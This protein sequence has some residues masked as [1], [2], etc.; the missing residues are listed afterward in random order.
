MKL[1]D[2]V[3]GEVGTVIKP[4]E[5]KYKKKLP[6]SFGPL[7]DKI[8]EQLRVLN[9]AIFPVRY[10]DKFYSDVLAAGNFAQLAYYSTDILVGAAC[11]RREEMEGGGA[12]L[13]LMTIGV[14]APYR[15]CGVGTALAEALVE[16]ASKAADVNEVY[17]HVQSS[18]TKGQEFY[19]R[20]GFNVKETIANFYK[21]ID[22]PDCHVMVKTFDRSKT[23]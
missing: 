9:K 8:V 19:T 6:V 12:R 20:L 13:Y 1:E 3:S 22:P 15:S 5:Q 14:L 18:N 21:D 4:T 16:T 17:V 2:F 11:C 7:T 10:N 23:A